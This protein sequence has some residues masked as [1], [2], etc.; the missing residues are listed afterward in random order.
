M[1]LAEGY[2][3]VVGVTDSR[4]VI[5]RINGTAPDLVLHDLHR[6]NLDGI[7]V[8][9]RFREA[10]AGEYLPIVVLTA[11]DSPAAKLRA[12]DAGATDFLTKPFDHVEVV[13]RIKHLLDARALHVNLEARVAERTRDLEDA[14]LEL[15][16]RL[17]LAAEYRD[18]E[19]HEHTQRVGRHAA[20]LAKR[21]GLGDDEA[22][23]IGA[24]AP[25]H[26][27]GKIGVSDTVLLKRGPLTR[28]E[29]SHMRSHAE[30]GARILS[31][32]QSAVLRLGEVV[33]RSHHERWDGAGYPDGLK[34]EGIPLEARIVAVVDVFDALTHARPYKPPWR[35]DEALAEIERQAGRAFDPRVAAAF[36]QM[37]REGEVDLSH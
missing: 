7:E 5:D 32:S 4:E 24:A 2:A 31:E 20:G 34:G 3:D 28:D 13:L 36:V 35:V 23:L 22:E 17:A 14:R 30:I 25:L 8:L 33:A 29:I 16:H 18:D 6:P 37:A 26:D 9:A 10:T 19:T 27:L 21:L 12:L 1:L 11:D 15:L